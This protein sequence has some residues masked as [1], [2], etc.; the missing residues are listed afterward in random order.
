MQS[1]G[2]LARR[3]PALLFAT[4]GAGTVAAATTAVLPLLVNSVV[5][6]STTLDAARG[7]G[8]GPAT[9]TATVTIV[10][11]VRYLLLVM[12]AFAAASASRYLAGKLALLVTNS[13]RVAVYQAN[14]TRRGS[15]EPAEVLSRAVNDLS[16]LQGAVL[17]FA[18][19]PTAAATVLFS[20][21]AASLLSPW[22]GAAIALQVLLVLFVTRAL[23]RP[24]ADAAAD[25]L[26]WTARLVHRVH[27]LVNGA[28]VTRAVRAERHEQD[29]AR[30]LGAQIRQ[31][32]VRLANRQSVLQTCVNFIPVAAQLLVLAVGGQAVLR[33][34]LGL[35]GL[36]SASIFLT[37]LTGM[38][39][40]VGAYLSQR[41]QAKVAL[42]RLVA[43]SD[44]PTVA[45]AAMSR[46]SQPE[47]AQVTTAAPDTSAD[48]AAHD[49]HDYVLA[50]HSG[51]TVVR[52]VPAN[53]RRQLVDAMTGWTQAADQATDVVTPPTATR[54][55]PNLA[56]PSTV[57]RIAVA[58]EDD[59]LLNGTIR[60]NLETDGPREE[61]AI[62]EVLRAVGLDELITLPAGLDTVLGSAGLTPSG[63]QH[64]RLV[65]ARAL[66]SRRD[67]VILDNPMSQVDP[68]AARQISAR[69][70][71]LV[72]GRTVLAFSDDPHLAKVADRL[73]ES[74]SADPPHLVP[75]DQPDPNGPCRRAGLDH[76]ERPV[77]PGDAPTDPNSATDPTVTDGV[78]GVVD[79]R[80]VDPEQRSS[81]VG[82]PLA[83]D[84][85]L[86]TRH[87]LSSVP[88]AFAVA[89]L[90]V[91]LAGLADLILP[92]VV[93]V[94]INSGV[95]S[96]QADVLR[97]ACLAGAAVV[98][99]G[100]AL[101][102]ASQ[103]AAN[104]MTERVVD[105]LRVSVLDSLILSD[106]AEV[107][108]RDEGDVVTRVITD[109]EA[110]ATYLRTGVVNVVAILVI[111]AGGLIALVLL[112]PTYGLVG[113][114]A[115][116]A[117]TALA[118]SYRR[119]VLPTYRRAR[120]QS[121]ATNDLL[122]EGLRTRRALIGWHR[123]QDAGATFAAAGRDYVRLRL[124]AHRQTTLFFESVT[125]TI[126]LANAAIVLLSLTGGPRDVGSIAAGL[127]YLGILLRPVEQASQVLDSHRQASVGL[128]R[129]AEMVRPR[130][131]PSVPRSGVAAI[132]LTDVTFTYPGSAKRALHRISTV[133]PAGST[134]AIVGGNGSGKSTLL[135]LLGGVYRPERGVV[136]LPEGFTE[137]DIGLTLQDAF[138]H[139]GPI[140]AAVRYGRP[141]ARTDE[142]D[143]AVLAAGS[144]P[145]LIE[146]TYGPLVQQ[147]G[148]ELA[149]EDRMALAVARAELRHPRIRL[150]DEPDDAR[151]L[152]TLSP[153]SGRDWASPAP[154]TTIVVTHQ[155][156]AASEANLILVLDRGRLVGR[157][158]HRELIISNTTYRRLWQDRTDP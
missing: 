110:T 83:G 104:G 25:T 79:G 7:T 30:S 19:M 42:G 60:F 61:S 9:G 124:Q 95:G 6:H 68:V 141:D 38:A 16:V 86:Q 47:W 122:S 76:V 115:L 154:T 29:A 67:T 105:R 40:V 128:S 49:L 34:Q 55:T 37:Q 129:L 11:A 125:L 57:P 120:D 59:V 72:S 139:D 35:A 96:G 87:L 33:G 106:L 98:V 134:I 126:R 112:N 144:D 77:P 100:A 44:D 3:R 116:L 81:R 93:K 135:K 80:G 138:L 82:V 64:Q 28:W 85:P 14:V 21:V 143:D 12:L 56:A 75:A 119:R 66:L 1:V 114:G 51:L 31:A 140:A 90:L 107:E 99:A 149:R 10:F 111:G 24:I 43:I 26:G 148:L 155:V 103:F 97:A 45:A 158:N 157:G 27:N 63:G 109:V 17:L 118:V 130:R 13:V 102:Y 18:V 121:A 92:W 88:F 84:P 153:E 54:H 91:L 113:L 136:A 123:Q 151:R 22:F 145:A 32:R 74:G 78:P 156:G 23:S 62:L 53:Q 2:R 46:T 133:I 137:T 94:G 108:T 147:D 41:E 131:R 71:A 4:V 117:C 89:L 142:V 146:Q 58:L 152:L 101:S 69:M 48:L 20:M 8:I 65:L 127:L 5:D 15:A 70:P 52:G 36:L 50:P 73:I 150:F 39:H 132:V